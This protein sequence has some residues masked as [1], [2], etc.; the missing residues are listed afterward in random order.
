VNAAS[1]SSARPV[2]VSGAFPRPG[3]GPR[4][5]TDHRC[6]PG[7]HDIGPTCHPSGSRARTSRAAR[8]R[9]AGSVLAD[10]VRPDRP[11]IQTPALFVR[12]YEDPGRKHR[13]PGGGGPGA[14]PLCAEHFRVRSMTRATARAWSLRWQRE[15]KFQRTRKGKSRRQRKPLVGSLRSPGG[16]PTRSWASNGWRGNRSDALRAA[17][18]ISRLVAFA[19][20]S[21]KPVGPTLSSMPRGGRDA[22]QRA[23]PQRARLIGG[24]ARSRFPPAVRAASPPAPLS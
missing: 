23:P 22:L 13:Y 11:P 24:L 3:C 8:S 20:S 18:P 6:E 19:K 1:S 12:S 14:S 4:A 17:A 10:R 7:S 21:N 16:V 5:V 15:R 2:T 9:A